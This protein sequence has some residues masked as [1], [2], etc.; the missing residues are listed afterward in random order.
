MHHPTAIP[1]DDRWARVDPD[2]LLAGLRIEHG[3][4]AAGFPSGI[5]GGHPC[6][7]AADH[8][9]LDLSP[10]DGDLGLNRS[11]RQVPGIEHGQWRLSGGGMAHDHCA[12]LGRNL[13]RPDVGDAVDRR[14]TVA[15]V[16][17][18]AQGAAPARHLAR[19]DDRDGD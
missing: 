14:E 19:T 5:D 6:I 17:G 13:A 1:D 8:D 9:H 12:W 15:A 16:T 7:A 3:N 18:Q 10:S 4:G 2:N 11:P